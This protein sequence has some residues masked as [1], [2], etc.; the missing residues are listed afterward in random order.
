MSSYMYKHTYKHNPNA[1]PA[2]HYVCVRVCMHI[3]MSTKCVSIN[4]LLILDLFSYFLIYKDIV[5]NVN[6]DL[7]TNLITI[8][9]CSPL[10]I[11]LPN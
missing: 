9:L 5:I 11:T 6:K 10:G 7:E 3:Y 1:H 8:I 2:P 4:W